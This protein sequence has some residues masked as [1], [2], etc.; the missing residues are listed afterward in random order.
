MAP[1]T[2]PRKQGGPDQGSWR[3]Q[4]GRH[5]AN[6]YQSS[7]VHPQVSRHSQRLPSFPILQRCLR[8]LSYNVLPFRLQELPWPTLIYWTTPPK[9]AKVHLPW[10]L[11]MWILYASG[12]WREGPLVST[13]FGTLGTCLM[14][15]WARW[16]FCNWNLTV[17]WW[18]LPAFIWTTDLD[19]SFWFYLKDGSGAR[20]NSTSRLLVWTN[21]EYPSKTAHKK[22]WQ[23]SAHSPRDRMLTWN[24]KKILCLFNRPRAICKF[25]VHHFPVSSLTAQSHMTYEYHVLQFW[26]GI[27]PLIPFSNDP[28]SFSPLSSKPFAVTGDI[29]QR[30][31]N[32]WCSRTTS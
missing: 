22:N 14:P 29:T 8:L 26:I 6:G 3:E 4:P 15:H 10:H 13:S 20:F 18:V 16:L 23:V 2:V 25:S 19:M 17:W 7:N 32:L 21:M 27:C 31:N 12:Q 5:C 24:S 1:R 28:K 11:I 9:C 30:E